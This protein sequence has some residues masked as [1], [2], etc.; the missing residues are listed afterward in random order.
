VGYRQAPEVRSL[1]AAEVDTRPEAVGVDTHPAGDSPVAGAGSWPVVEVDSHLVAEVDSYPA[2]E[3]ET[4]S[5][6]D[7]EAG[8]RPV[9]PPLPDSTAPSPASRPALLFVVEPVSCFI[10]R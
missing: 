3:A 9:D 2:A 6:R 5:P 10:R 4:D 8:I 7:L 1:P